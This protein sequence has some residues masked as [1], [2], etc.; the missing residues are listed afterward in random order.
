MCCDEIGVYFTINER[1]WGLVCCDDANGTQNRLEVQSLHL[2]CA[3]K[4]CFILDDDDD[5]DGDGNGDH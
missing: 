4:V 1:I 3:K 5:G 2:I